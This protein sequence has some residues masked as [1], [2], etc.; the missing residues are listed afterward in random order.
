MT[1]VSENGK[2]TAKKPGTTTVT[3]RD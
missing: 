3:A 2:V 1:S